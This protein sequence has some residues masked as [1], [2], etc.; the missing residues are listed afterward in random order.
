MTA[1][2]ESHSIPP[3]VI[4]VY[5]ADE[6]LCCP[7]GHKFPETSGILQHTWLVCTRALA[8][9]RGGGTR[10]GEFVYVV[11]LGDGR[12]GVARVDWREA[13]HMAKLGMTVAEAAEFLRLPRMEV[14]T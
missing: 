14:T 10:C 11:K 12:F 13:Y 8:N 9:A 6:P 3:R 2:T 7:F 4:R 5:R 1:P